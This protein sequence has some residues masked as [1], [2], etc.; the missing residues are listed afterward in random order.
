MTDR[1]FDAVLQSSGIRR[2]VS[3]FG[4][5]TRFLPA[6]DA[7][8]LFAPRFKADVEEAYRAEQ[9]DRLLGQTRLALILGFLLYGA[10]GFVDQ[11]IA[12]ARSRELWF[13]RFAVVCPII[14]ATYA[15]SFSRHFRRH[16][17]LALCIPTGV[18]GFGIIAMSAM[19]PSPGNYVYY[20]GLVLLV[21]YYF[22]LIRLRL[23]YAVAVSVILT[24]TYIPVALVVA[25]T[26]MPLFGYNL[27]VIGTANVLGVY[28][29]LAM[30]TYARREF[31][32]RQVIAMK[33]VELEDRNA[34]LVARNQQLA[35]SRAEIARSARETELV[36]SALSEALPGK[37]LNEKYR[38]EAKIGGGGFGTVYRGTHLQLDYPVAVKVLRPQIGSAFGDLERFRLEGISACRLRHPNAVVVIDFGV[39][40]NAVAYL[41]MELLEG[42]SLAEVL[43]ETRVLTPMRCADIIGPVCDVLAM[44]HGAGIV[45]RDIKPSNIILHRSRDGEVA[46][47]IDFG[48]AKLLDHAPGSHELS[49]ATETGAFL[50]TVAY[51][52]PERIDNRPYDGR[53]DVYS[54]AVTAYEMLCGRPP[55]EPGQR[56]A[57]AVAAA[58]L[59]ERPVSARAINPAVPSRLDELLLQA[60]DKDPAR[61]PAS[62]EFG[63]QFREAARAV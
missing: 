53:A 60:L 15:F 40:G 21:I 12:P 42:P 5:A 9:F 27:F 41:V 14:A 39:A 62:I 30:E 51:M 6:Y 36:F 10:F 61:R 20:A 2:I 22:T 11:W 47:V 24:A 1:S 55:F 3:A 32:Q 28:A 50:G 7:I 43:R 37:V 57:W 19:I 26:P 35:R 8:G 54:T 13:I 44:A 23:A 17:Q 48:I 46:K 31:R 16:K 49:P 18:G 33:S 63:A 25:H 59:T 38:I 52:A 4:S 56:G 58:H 34:E 29:N 45:H